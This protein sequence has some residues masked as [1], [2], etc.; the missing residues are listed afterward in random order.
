MRLDPR[1][2][3]MSPRFLLRVAFAA[4]VLAAVLG[5]LAQLA[6]GRRPVLLGGETV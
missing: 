4:L 1:L 3:V 2:E 5:A 6:A